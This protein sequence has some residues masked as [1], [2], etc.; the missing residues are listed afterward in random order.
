MLTNRL[1][2][3]TLLVKQLSS[4]PHGKANK[5]ALPT[6]SAVFSSSEHLERLHG[7][8][9]T[10]VSRS[11]LTVLIATAVKLSVLLDGIVFIDVLFLKPGLLTT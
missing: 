7:S 3:A 11:G 5:L 6:G 1:S 10:N 4:L 2:L 8:C 9:R